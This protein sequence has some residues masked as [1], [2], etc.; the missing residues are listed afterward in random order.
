LRGLHCELSLHTY[1]G[2]QLQIRQDGLY[3]RPG[4]RCAGQYQRRK[5]L[6]DCGSDLRERGVRRLQSGELSER[7]LRQQRVRNNGAIGN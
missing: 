3:E 1:G 5:D 2:Q 7:M 6:R 4:V